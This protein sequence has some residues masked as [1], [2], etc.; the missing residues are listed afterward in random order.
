MARCEELA[1]LARKLPTRMQAR[2]EAPKPA[3]GGW[4]D[5]A[6]ATL[7]QFIRVRRM[8]A[9]EA[10]LVNPLFADTARE[11]L[12]LRLLLAK[13]ALAQ[14]EDQRYRAELERAAQR[15]ASAFAETDPSAREFR[16][17]L[18]S[19]LDA[20]PAPPLPEVGRALDELRNLRATRALADELRPK[21]KDKDKP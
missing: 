13:S 14:G 6:E 17:G 12:A 10:A 3:P 15:A 1:E 16:D 5:R 4:L 20:P 21:A 8:D 9:T 19:L 2:D 11:A 7:A 18:K